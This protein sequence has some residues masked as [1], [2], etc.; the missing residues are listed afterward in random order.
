MGNGVPVALE[1]IGSAHAA[2]RGGGLGGKSGEKGERLHNNNGEGEIS[3]FSEEKIPS[4]EE[5]DKKKRKG[6]KNCPLG[7]ICLL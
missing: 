4:C 1:E 2:S 7:S 6:E 3:A 5:A